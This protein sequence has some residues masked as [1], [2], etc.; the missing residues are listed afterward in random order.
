[1]RAWQ[2]VKP[3]RPQDVLVL[4]E[5]CPSPEAD[6]ATLLVEVLAAGMGFPDVFMCHGNYI[7]TPALPFT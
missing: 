5:D 1:V 2:T 7:L 3:G 4:N 6:P